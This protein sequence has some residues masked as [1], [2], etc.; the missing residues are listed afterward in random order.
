MGLY[1]AILIKNNHITRAGGVRAAV[2]AQ[3]EIADMPIEIEVRTR[4][5]IEEGLALGVSRL[6]L[7]NMT[8]AQAP[9]RS[10][11][12]AGRAH[13]RVVGRHHARPAPRI[14]RNRSRLHLRGRHHALGHR[15]RIST[16]AHSTSMPR[17]RSVRSLPG[18]AIAGSTI[19]STMH[20]ASPPRRTQAAASGTVVGADEQTAGTAVMAGSGTSEPDTGLY[21]SIVLRLPSRP[22]FVPLVTLA[23]GLGD[24]GGHPQT[25]G[26]A[27]DLRWPNDVLIGDRKCAGILTQLH[28]H[29]RDRRHR[30]QR[31]SDR[32]FPP[33]VARIATSLR[34]AS[35]SRNRAKRSVTA[36]L[37]EIDRHCDMLTMQGPAAIFDLFTHA[38]SYVA[39]R[40]VTVDQP[41]DPIYGDHG[42]SERS[43]FLLLDAR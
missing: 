28:G 19:D 39:G 6:L 18:R 21:F 15:R 35:G 20:D 43:R 8:P 22:C 42:R 2:E 32:A 14:R 26:V 11:F 12:I 23:L 24:C 4:E 29:R 10:Q 33:T 30:H 17:P 36:L 27:C 9:R 13:G 3:R 16:S 34:I 38:S 41:E 7:D 5:E 37:S 25:T 40:R 31:Q 1:D